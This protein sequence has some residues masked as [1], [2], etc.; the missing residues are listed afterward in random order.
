MPD[1]LPE[2]GRAAIAN[3]GRSESELKIGERGEPVAVDV[4]DFRASLDDAV[5]GTLER[6]ILGVLS[7]QRVGITSRERLLMTIE[8]RADLVAGHR[9]PLAISL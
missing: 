5:G 9:R 2:N 6:A 4:G 8:Q 3:D 7:G 1:E